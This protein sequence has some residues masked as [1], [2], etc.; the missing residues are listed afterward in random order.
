MPPGDE[1]RAGQRS[2][3]EESVDEKCELDASGA[4]QPVQ[5]ELGE[6]LLVGPVPAVGAQAARDLTRRLGPNAGIATRAAAADVPADAIPLY[7]WLGS[8]PAALATEP[9]PPAR[10][11]W[12]R[13]IRF[14]GS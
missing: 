4:E 14:G 7:H 3:R 5:A 11:V 6:P 13:R 1:R 2:G 8:R 9:S 10:R 12:F